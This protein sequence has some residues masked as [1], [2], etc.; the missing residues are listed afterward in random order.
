VKGCSESRKCGYNVVGVVYIFVFLCWS[1]MTFSRGPRQG[2][3]L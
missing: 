1:V 3:A 2:S